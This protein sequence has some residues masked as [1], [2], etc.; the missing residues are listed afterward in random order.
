MGS[1]EEVEAELEEEGAEIKSYEVI[2]Q[3][4]QYKTDKIQVG[5]TFLNPNLF[6]IE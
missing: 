4:N 1:P 3:L 5:Q 2:N 6:I